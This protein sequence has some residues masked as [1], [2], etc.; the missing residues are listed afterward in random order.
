EAATALV[1]AL[2]KKGARGLLFRYNLYLCF[3]RL[4][5]TELAGQFSRGLKT[6]NPAYGLVLGTIS[7][8]HEAEPATIT[9][10]RYL[11]PAAPFTHPSRPAK[12]YYPPPCV[13]AVDTAGKRVSIDAANCLPED[14]PEGYKYSLGAVTLGVR[15]ATPPGQDP[16]TNTSPVTPIGTLA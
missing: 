5:D 12:P 6:A 8:W 16:S 1:A 14:G 10:G 13:A 3:P 15:Q 4:S 2:R 9:L 7:P 11:K